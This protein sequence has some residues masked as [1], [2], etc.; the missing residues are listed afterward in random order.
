MLGGP[1]DRPG[2]TDRSPHTGGGVSTPRRSRVDRAST[3]LGWALLLCWTVIS[4]WAWFLAPQQAT[5]A[6]LEADVALGRTDEVAMTPGLSPRSRGFS[7]VEVRWRSGLYT[8]STEV[9]ES[10]PERGDERPDGV[11]GIGTERPVVEDLATQLRAL[12]PSLAVDSMDRPSGVSVG[13]L[14]RELSGAVAWA[15]AAAFVLTLALI[16]G[17]NEPWRATRWA[18][19]WLLASPVMPLAAIAFLVLGG[20]LPL[21][22]PPPPGARRLTGGFAFILAWVVGG[23]VHG[24]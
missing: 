6:E 20:V 18:W 24:G 7:V 14:G 17:L 11:D 23:L 21:V 5:L 22:G 10:R 16:T 8:Y 13:M 2:R 1:A 12:Q 19:F 4:A 3:Y 9:V 15:T